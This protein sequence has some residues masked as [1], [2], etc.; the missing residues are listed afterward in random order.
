MGK[1]YYLTF[2]RVQI[3][4][5]IFIYHNFYATAVGININQNLLPMSV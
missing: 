5:M 1:K 2:N 3:N 4:E